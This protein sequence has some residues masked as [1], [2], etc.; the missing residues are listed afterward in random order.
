MIE[1]D[2]E[3]SGIQARWDNET[4]RTQPPLLD[5]IMVKKVPL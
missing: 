4:A 1:D 2:Q 5:C 3:Q